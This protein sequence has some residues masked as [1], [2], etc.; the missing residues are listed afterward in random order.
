MTKPLQDST[1]LVV[2]AGGLGAPACLQLATAGVGRIVLCDD[3]A[4]EPADLTWQP[5]LG[6]ADVGRR[7]AAAS[8]R[9][10]AALFPRLRVEGLDQRLD[11]SC[12]SALLASADVVA[13]CSGHFATMF[14]LNDTAV[15]AGKALVHGAA[16][17]LTAHV[18]TVLPGTT[19]CLRCLF[20]G[21]PP[22]G[23]A[24]GPARIGVFGPLAGFAGALVGREAIRLLGGEASAHAGLLLEYEA[25]SARTRT[26]P[27]RRRPGCTGCAAVSASAPP[28]NQPGAEEPG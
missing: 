25:R 9:R 7:K 1:V 14:L 21:P 26:V 4:V 16:V 10:L 28:M 18:L 5:L 11:A 22:P 3:G 15:G 20:E 12:A 13:D 2:G 27:I 23:A 8:A 17:G 19:G 6:E 24:L